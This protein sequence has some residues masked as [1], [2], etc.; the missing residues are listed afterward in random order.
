MWPVSATLI[1]KN[2]EAVIA[3]CLQ[4]LEGCA[5]III[6]DSGSTDATLSI[7]EKFSQLGWPI[8]LFRRDWPGYAAQRQFALEQAT[9]DWALMI[10]ADERLDAELRADFSRLIAQ[11]GSAVGVKL[12]RDRVL[13]GQDHAAPARAEHILRLTR[14]AATRFDPA[15]LVHEGPLVE[16]AVICAPRGGLLHCRPLRLDRQIAKEARYA[17]LKAE[18]RVAAGGKPALYRLV[19]NPLVYFLRILLRDR[20]FV[21]GRAGVIHAGVGAIYSFLTEAVHFQICADIL[22]KPASPWG[23]IHDF[24]PDPALKNL[25]A[26]LIC[27]DEAGFIGR[28]VASLDGFAEIIV[29]DSGS[30]DGTLEILRDFLAHGWP[31]RLI[32]RPWPGYAK[33]KQFAWEQATG[34]WALSIDSDEWLDADLRRDLPRLIDQSAVEAW[35]L[36]RPLAVYGRESEQPKGT[37]PERITRLARR[38]TVRFDDSALVHEGL[39]VEGRIGESAKGFLRHDRALRIDGQ[40]LKETTYA[41]LKAEQRVLR[42]KKPSLLKLLLNPPLYFLRIFFSNR[43]FSYGVDG[44]ILAGTRACYSFLGEALHWQLSRRMRDDQIRHEGQ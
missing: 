27:Q 32:E 40:I 7:I 10:D 14:R 36:R 35:K 33:Q 19:F 26:T 9:Q 3:D 30:T 8:K 38:A 12:R 15:V 18:Q 20:W 2:E 24:S 22:R 17:R 23:E 25:S 29:V 16:G 21:A 4:S 1:C 5:E 34:A 11:A 44:Y 31:I 28:C 42:G 6:V 43:M 41:R 13:F 39:V 37:R